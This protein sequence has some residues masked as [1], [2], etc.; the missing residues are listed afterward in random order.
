MDTQSYKTISAN[1]AT[2]NK[3][4]VVVDATDQVL[5]RFAAKI[6]VML[7]GK[8]KTNFTPH[9]DCGDNVIVLNA[10]KVRLTGNKMTQKQYLSHTGYPGGQR[11]T[12]PKELLERKPLAVPRVY[13]SAGKG[14]ITINGSPIDEYFKEETLKYIVNQP[15]NLTGTVANFD[16]K[17]NIDGGG[18]KGQA[19]ALRLAISRALCK[20]DE[21]AY[22]PVLKSNGFLTRDAREVERKKPGQPG[23]RKRFQFSKR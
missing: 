11:V 2:V 16:I 21:E 1:S 14:N 6:A 17:A 22:R 20:V 7:R 5:G 18:V 15:L 4:W 10:G 23:A 9:V 12:T 8:H 13:L 3:E 19:E